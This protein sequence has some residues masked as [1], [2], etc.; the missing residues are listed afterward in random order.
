MF[1]STIRRSSSRNSTAE[2]SVSTYPNVCNICKKGRIQQCAK[3]VEPIKMAT[4]EAQATV[5]AAA[6]VKD[7]DMFS[8][9]QDLDL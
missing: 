2:G 3:K 9:I 1:S 7:E 6:K 5:K 8:E 4:F